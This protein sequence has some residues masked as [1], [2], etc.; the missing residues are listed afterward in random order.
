M[1]R[2]RSHIRPHERPDTAN[3]VTLE[4]FVDREADGRWVVEFPALPGV[5]TYGPNRDEAVVTAK[6]IA[7]RVLADRLEHGEVGPN[8]R[9]IIFVA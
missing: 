4:L 6:A 7:L 8:L 9:E 5:M 3:S 2:K 1:A